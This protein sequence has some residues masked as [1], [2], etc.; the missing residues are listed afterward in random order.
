MKLKYL[1]LLASLIVFGIVG[2]MIHI[3]SI[4]AEEYSKFD[5]SLQAAY[6]AV[7]LDIINTLYFPIILISHLILFMI[8]KYKDSKK[9][10]AD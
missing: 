10:I 5:G 9:S 7:N 3:E 2:V 6:A 4:K 8:F 1:S